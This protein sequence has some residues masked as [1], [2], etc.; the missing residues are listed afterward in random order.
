[1]NSRWAVIEIL[2]SQQV[3]RIQSSMKGGG[4]FH[5][6]VFLHLSDGLNVTR[7]Q[8]AQRD[9]SRQAVFRV[10]LEMAFKAES[11][12][13]TGPWWQLGTIPTLVRVVQNWGLP[14]TPESVAARLGTSRRAVQ[15]SR[16]V[17][18]HACPD[19]GLSVEREVARKFPGAREPLHLWA[20]GESPR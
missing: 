9:L 3:R 8:V 10:W 19:R 13:T 5:H 14:P 4:S 15:L 17:F 1:M 2:L 7:R 16:E 12:R 18:G 20:Q 11:E 6:P